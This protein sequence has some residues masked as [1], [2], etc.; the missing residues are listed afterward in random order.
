MKYLQL[1]VQ[2]NHSAR[3]ITSVPTMSRLVML[4]TKDLN[5]ERP[6]ALHEP[7]SPSSSSSSSPPEEAARPASAAATQRTEKKHAELTATGQ[8]TRVLTHEAVWKRFGSKRYGEGLEG[9]SHLFDMAMA[10]NPGCRALG[11]I[12]V[13]SPTTSVANRVK[14]K[15]WAQLALRVGEVIAAER[16]TASARSNAASGIERARKRSKTVPSTDTAQLMDMKQSGLY[17]GALDSSGDESEE[18]D[19]QA[20]IAEARMLVSAWRNQKVR[21]HNSHKLEDTRY[22]TVGVVAI[23][24]S[25]SPGLEEPNTPPNNR[26]FK[27]KNNI[28]A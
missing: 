28:C 21:A 4:L 23:V 3:L 27:K 22:N 15:V 20:I 24:S 10:L 9:S 8:A 19:N 13:L 7:S 14:A 18:E 2:G 1:V 17:D 5:V 16:A 26:P 12:D 6:L 11:Y 25:G